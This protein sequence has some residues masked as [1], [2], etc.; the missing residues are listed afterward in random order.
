MK[1]LSENETDFFDLAEFNKESSLNS[2]KS[3]NKRW[4]DICTRFLPIFSKET[5]WRYSRI[6]EPDDPDQGWKLHI[7]A[8]ILSAPEVLETVAPFLKTKGALFK[9]PFSLREVKKINSGIYYNYSQVGKIITVYPKTNEQAVFFAEQLH[10][11][12]ENF[13]APAVP[14][15][16]QFKPNS[17]VFYRYG[18]FKTFELKD[19][20]GS[21][22]LAM[23]DLDGK[24]VPDL[25]YAQPPH[26][27]WVSNP[28]A[29]A[30]E[31]AKPSDT[32]LAK[33]YKVFRALTQRG[34][35]GVYQAVDFSGDVPRFCLVKEGRKNGEIDWDGRDGFWRVRHESRVLKI[36]RETGINVPQIYSSF[37]TTKSFY[38][39]TEFIEGETLHAFL[40]KRQRRLGISQAIKYS[41]QLSKLIAQIHSAGWLWRDCKPGNLIISRYE[42]LRPIDF[43][44]ACPINQPDYI[45]Y[46]TLFPTFSDESENFREYRINPDLF[47]LG[48]I[49]YLLFEGQL[50][51]VTNTSG[52][53]QILRKVPDEIKLLISQ[54]LN[55][56]PT[57]YPSIKTVTQ[58]LERTLKS[59]KT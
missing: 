33:N 52:A 45:Q 15:D 2:A 11:L 25:R 27:E 20:D 39:V 28:F 54:L 18:A 49:I 17:S 6:Y 26:P 23:R 37:E 46:G 34:K 43:E 24:L 8:T 51:N 22:I 13:S 59:A 1:A 10:G 55:P 32:P 35:G 38:L 44:G 12:T 16:I 30:S 58:K 36:L 9:A 50:P 48:S 56:N 42:G 47:A 4:Q 57:K 29:A 21:K 53:P 14:F 41:I 31:E 3:L 19:A 7:S 5:V 40:Q